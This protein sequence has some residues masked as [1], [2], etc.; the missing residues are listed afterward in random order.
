MEKRQ[1]F[2]KFESEYMKWCETG[3]RPSACDRDSAFLLE[4]QRKRLIKKAIHMHCRIKDY[5]PDLVEFSS[6]GDKFNAYHEVRSV[7]RELEFSGEGRPQFRIKN[8]QLMVQVVITD[9][10][11]ETLYERSYECPNCGAVSN[12]RSLLAGCS[13]CGTRFLIKDLFPVVNNFWFV[14]DDSNET[15]DKR[16][17]R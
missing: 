2:D 4:V 12:V 14:R 17:K 8:D 10:H 1:I 7:E 13:Y 5:E 3:E 11:P 6:K 16:E 15:L 9:E